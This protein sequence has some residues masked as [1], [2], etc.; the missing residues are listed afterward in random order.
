M[1]TLF[2]QKFWLST[3][4]LDSPMENKNSENGTNRFAC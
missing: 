3:D 4:L 2:F 1:W